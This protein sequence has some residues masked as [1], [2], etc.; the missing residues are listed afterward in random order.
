MFSQRHINDVADKNTLAKYYINIFEPQD[1]TP[2][3][4]RVFAEVFGNHSR[5][6]NLIPR[7]FWCHECTEKYINNTN[8][9]IAHL[10]DNKT[11]PEVLTVLTQKVLPKI[12][13]LNDMVPLVLEDL[14]VGREPVNTDTI[15]EFLGINMD[16]YDPPSSEV[17]G[18]CETRTCTTSS[19][20]TCAICLCN[21]EV[22]DLV[23]ELICHHSFHDGCVMGWL[24][25]NSTCPICKGSLKTTVAVADLEPYNFLD[26]LQGVPEE[27][28]EP[29]PEQDENM[30][31]EEIELMAQELMNRLRERMNAYYA[32]HH[33]GEHPPVNVG[34]HVN[35]NGFPPVTIHQ[36][37]NFLESAGAHVEFLHREVGFTEEEDDEEEDEED[38][39]PDLVNIDSESESESES[40]ESEE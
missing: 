19:D 15:Y 35:P 25:N 36:L 4:I 22:G 17:L 34:I 24:K 26:V 16:P 37:V 2:E 39:M 13:L 11:F 31:L 8:L 30:D 38:E 21:F 27:D 20:D 32:E 7:P 12:L 29:E 10:E 33:P 23:K 5:I 14:R 9:I 40:D 18:R 28:P 1:R 6:C 3:L